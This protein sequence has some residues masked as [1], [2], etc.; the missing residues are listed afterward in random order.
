[1]FSFL[2]VIYLFLCYTYYMIIFENKNKE[3]VALELPHEANKYIPAMVEQTLG[4]VSSI[5]HVPDSKAK[6]CCAT[7]GGYTN[8]TLIWTTKN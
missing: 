1:M 2:I 8:A 7:E 3:Y 5:W 6:G 4:E